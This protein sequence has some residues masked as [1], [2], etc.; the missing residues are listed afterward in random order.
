MNEIEAPNKP[1][2]VH[3]FHL[4]NPM[5][6]SKTTILALLILSLSTSF[7]QSGWVNKKGEIFSQLAYQSFSSE[8]YVNLSGEKQ[9]TTKF[10]YK[11]LQLYT[12]Y[13]VTDKLTTIIS[14]P[15][16]TWQSFERTKTVSGMGD[17]RVE[18]K[19]P[20]AQKGINVAISIAPEIPIGRSNLY[21]Q[22]K[23]LSF[24]YINLPTGD[25]EFNVWST[26]AASASHASLPLYATLH[27]GFNYRTKFEAIDFL[28]Q[29][30]NGIKVG[31]KAID[32]MWLE[33]QITTLSSLGDTEGLTEFVR[34]N[35]T[36]YTSFSVGASYEVIPKWSV[37]LKYFT[38]TNWIEKTRNV[39][40]ADVFSVGVYYQKKEE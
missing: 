10:Y 37:S 30:T 38:N 40:T 24:E 26:L 36:E 2:F 18:L 28:H 3:F 21:S 11:S 8:D 33:T 4:P 14:L 35:G 15:I 23:E 6:A 32:K 12:E 5:Q 9:A 13:G 27:T 16:Q 7:S 39:Y 29:W 1:R 25:G 22:S 19:Y 34:G 17:L 31:Y 20:L